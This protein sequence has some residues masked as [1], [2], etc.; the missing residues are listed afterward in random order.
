MMDALQHYCD[1]LVAALE[2]Y[3]IDDHYRGHE[4]KRAPALPRS[5]EAPKGVDQ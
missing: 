1:G 3:A 2:W 4:P 5:P